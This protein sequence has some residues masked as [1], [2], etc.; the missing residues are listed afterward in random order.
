MISTRD[1]GLA[2]KL[3]F[4]PDQHTFIATNQPRVAILRDQGINGQLEMAAAFRAAGFTAIDVH[5]TDLFEGRE[6]LD[7]FQVL[8][9]C[10]G[11]SYG[12][13]LGGGGGWAKSILYSAE[14]RD[15]FARFFEQDTL[16]LGICNGCQMLAQLQDLVP[17]AEEWVTWAP[18]RSGRFEG[19]TVQV[20]ASTASIRHG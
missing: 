14:L 2:E 5:M 12:D 17:G 11:F 1:R 10:G 6:S 19:R 16:T 7:R 3:S 4:D 18:N 13:V 9:A 20:R 15:Q 8:A